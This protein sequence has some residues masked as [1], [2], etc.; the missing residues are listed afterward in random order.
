MATNKKWYSKIKYSKV[1]FSSHVV[2]SNLASKF[3][4]RFSQIFSR[5]VTIVNDVK[6]LYIYLLVL[7]DV[8]D[9]VDKILPWLCVHD[10]I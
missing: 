8:E 1:E 9:E 3:L 2:I 5:N 7:H 10:L 6:F 4:G